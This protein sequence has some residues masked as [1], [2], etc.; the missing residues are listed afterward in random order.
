PSQLAA[1]IETAGGQVTE[2]GY[3]QHKPAGPADETALY[4]QKVKAILDP[5]A[6]FGPLWETS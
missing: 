3:G 6:V 1:S 5:D 2:A 4:M